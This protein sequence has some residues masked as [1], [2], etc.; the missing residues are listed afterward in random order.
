MFG[1]SV[2]EKHDGYIGWRAILKGGYID[3]VHNRC[4]AKGRTE[5]Q[6]RLMAW[7]NKPMLVVPPGKKRA[8]KVTPWKRMQNAAHLHSPSRYN[9]WEY[10]EGNFVLRCNTC[11]SHGYLYIA[12]FEGYNPEQR[13]RD[14]LK[15]NPE[16]ALMIAEAA[17]LGLVIVSDIIEEKGKPPKAIARIIADDESY[18]S[19]SDYLDHVD[20]Y[21]QR[22]PNV[23]TAIQQLQGDAEEND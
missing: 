20:S 23:Y 17:V 18:D 8:I 10:R 6:D 3:I 7:V 22:A 19:A 12:L 21:I 11:A 4:Y 5:S 2:K 1:L 15:D 13:L 16:E 9:D 14:V